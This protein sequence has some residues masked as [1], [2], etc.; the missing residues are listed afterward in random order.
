MYSERVSR[1]GKPRAAKSVAEL[2]AIECELHKL[3]ALQGSVEEQNT[4][5]H[6]RVE[7]RKAQQAAWAATKRAGSKVVVKEALLS[8][9]GIEEAIRTSFLAEYPEKKL[10]KH[11]DKFFRFVDVII[12]EHQT[13][14]EVESE[15]LQI[16][17]ARLAAYLGTTLPFT[18]KVVRERLETWG[19]IEV[20]HSWH[21]ATNS[22]PGH[23]KTYRVGD[24]FQG[25]DTVF[26]LVTKTKNKSGENHELREK[27]EKLKSREIDPLVVCEDAVHIQWL[28]Y[29]LNRLSIDQAASF[30]RIDQL[31]DQAYPLRSKRVKEGN[32]YVLRTGRTCTAEIGQL[33]KDSVLLFNQNQLLGQAEGKLS[34]TNGR[35]NTGFTRLF[36]C[37]RDYTLVDGKPVKLVSLDLGASQPYLLIYLLRQTTVGQA[38]PEALNAFQALLDGGSF[39][40]D[41][42]R[43][44]LAT[45]DLII[46]FTDAKTE[47]FRN[48]IFSKSHR[49]TPY[50]RA[51]NDLFPLVNQAL[52]E[53][54][55]KGTKVDASGKLVKTFHNLAIQLQRVESDLFLNQMLPRLH[56]EL[57]QDAF[58]TTVHD[59]FYCQPEHA[60]HIQAMMEEVLLAHTNQVPVIKKN[61]LISATKQL[62]AEAI[63]FMNQQPIVPTTPEE[64]FQLLNPKQFQAPEPRVRGTI[65]V[66]HS[67]EELPDYWKQQ[68]AIA[69]VQKARNK[70]V[71]DATVVNNIF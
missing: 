56:Q 48:V 71:S 42:L 23:C 25:N 11:L 34:V 27:L 58:L 3:N 61:G 8:K 55:T 47:F 52:M 35:Y 20:G 14:Q 1:T 26:T 43:Q 64:L 4:I 37:G 41:I 10:G 39:Y 63:T 50:R 5:I 2:R 54:V 28:K 31:V 62:A 29:N 7:R 6:S 22:D 70:A 13:K 44:V 16:K 67:A 24:T 59:S 51:F 57:G 9:E 15:L 38:Q 60:D 66:Y 21:A 40:E 45:T 69:Q 32:R 65:T 12:R 46:P 49:N 33:Y 19:I 68:L 30:A 18:Y 17:G 36:T 53:L